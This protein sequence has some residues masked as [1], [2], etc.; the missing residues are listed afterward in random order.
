MSS[1]TANVK[2]TGSGNNSATITPASTPVATVVN[3]TNGQSSTQT[4]PPPNINAPKYGKLHLSLVCL[5]LCTILSVA[6]AIS[7]M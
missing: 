6:T 7:C 3:M 1:G 2:K 5:M 4:S